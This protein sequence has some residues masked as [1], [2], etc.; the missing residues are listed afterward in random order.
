MGKNRRPD[1][2]PLETNDLAVVTLGTMAWV[3]AL[4]TL[5][6]LRD[7]LEPQTRT[8]WAWVCAAGI[9]LGLIGLRHVRRRQAA[10]RHAAATEAHQG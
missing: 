6:A 10:R 2:E 8:Q 3:V 7:A 9:F 4:V 1:P 5:F